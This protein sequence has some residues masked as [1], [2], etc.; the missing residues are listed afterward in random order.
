MSEITTVIVP[1]LILYY[2]V[3]VHLS[4]VVYCIFLTLYIFTRKEA[5]ILNLPN[6]SSYA[7]ENLTKDIASKEILS[8]ENIREVLA[9]EKS[10]AL[11]SMEKP[12]QNKIE[13]NSKLLYRIEE[14]G[15][16]STS[17]EFTRRGMLWSRHASWHLPLAPPRI[18]SR[19]EEG[20]Q[21]LE[22][23]IDILKR[24]DVDPV[25]GFLPSHDP[26]QRLPYARYHIWW[27]YVPILLL[28]IAVK[29]RL[30]RLQ[31]GPGRR[32]V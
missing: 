12:S 10:L 2:G 19:I 23:V 29:L 21:G 32:F 3:F 27:D 28:Q 6:T 5:A 18:P 15:K 7:N 1:T 9:S 26:L 31:G 30:L 16:K 13:K 24:F 14:E 17:T 11:N 22:Q 8:S 4:L 20:G 25:R